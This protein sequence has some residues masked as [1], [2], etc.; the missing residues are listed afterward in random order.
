MVIGYWLYIGCI[1]AS[2][3]LPLSV[4]F[5]LATGNWPVAFW[6]L[7]IGY[8]LLAIGNCLLAIGYWL[9]A[10]GYWL[11]AIG[12]WLLTIGNWPVQLVNRGLARLSLA[13][14]ARSVLVCISLS[15]SV[16]VYLSLSWSVLVCL[17]LSRFVRVCLRS[18]QSE[19]YAGKLVF[20]RARSAVG[21]QG[22][23]CLLDSAH[24]LPI[25]LSHR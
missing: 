14:T 15:R 11:L 2:G 4:G 21:C 16:S 22:E 19:A 7:E 18:S 17:G 25:H 5:F 9:L 23:E 12:Y 10:T 20:G 13:R 1:L 3:Y 8:W 24:Q 6:L